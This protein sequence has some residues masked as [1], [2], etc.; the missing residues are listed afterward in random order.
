MPASEPGRPSL[1]ERRRA[2]TRLDIA[3]TAARLFAEHGTAEVTA[4][5]IA[6]AS[7]VG[8]RTF[9][10]YARTKQDAV[11]PMLTT[12]AQRWFETIA[13]G[14]RRLPT[15]GEL[16]AAAVRALSIA[17]GEDF[18]LTRGLLRAMENDPALRD[19]WH[20]INLDG[21]R[22][23][24]TVL[25]ELAGPDA[26]PVRLRLLAAA[27][28]GAIRIALEEWAVASPSDPVDPA[29]LVVRCMR[30]LGAGI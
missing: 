25:A 2:E 8:L 4:E 20:R 27:A 5:Q 26:D 13:A 14:P 28:A 22:E 24:R 7:G 30:A 3:R 29:A 15:L 17:D 16:E 9:Y 23:L 1:A 12:G 19:V 10:R 6:A 11:E 18:E 21:E